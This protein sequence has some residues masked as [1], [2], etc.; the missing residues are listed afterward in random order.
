MRNESIARPI[1]HVSAGF[2]PQIY[3]PLARRPHNIWRIAWLTDRHSPHQRNRLPMQFHRSLPSGRFAV[4]SRPIAAL[5]TLALALALA[6]CTG[7]E[8]TAGNGGGGDAKAAE[9]VEKAPGA[10]AGGDKPATS[11]SRQAGNGPSGAGGPVTVTTVAALKR[12]FDIRTETTGAVVPMASVDIRPQT[13]AA[14]NE[15]HVQE[16]QTVRAGQVLFTLD[17]RLDAANVGKLQAQL[18]RDQ[19]AL[20]DAERQAQRARSLVQQQFLAQG[21][22][23]TSQAQADGLRA[24]VAADMA[25]VKAAQLATA[26]GKIQA[27]MAGRLGIIAVRKGSV[28]QANVTSL[29]TLTQF[30]PIEVAFSLPQRQ[31]PGLLTNLRNGGAEVV[32]RIADGGQEVR[33]RLQFVDSAVDPATGTIKVK[34]R[35]ANADQ[36][37]WPGAFVNVALKSDT[38]A[39]ATVIPAAAI[40]QSPRGSSVYVNEAGKAAV[41]PVKMLALQG[42]DAAVS[43]VKPGEL[44]VLDGRQNLR[45]G[46]TIKEQ[47]PAGAKGERT[48]KGQGGGKPATAERGQP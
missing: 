6:A 39:G 40:I 45:P 43:G 17:T 23:D 11:P 33:G 35:F 4:R 12:D 34:A 36:L 28:V 44:V 46:A 3:R 21:A 10:S 47:A 19:V 22:A 29:V 2:A 26:F 27:P 30:D 32:V 37:L 38:L 16:G 9:S 42:D 41:R 25:A 48:G 14:V 18:A 31:L 1:S 15:V 13:T 7:R 24:A 5:S 8:P 20:A